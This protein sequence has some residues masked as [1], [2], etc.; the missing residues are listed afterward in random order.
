MISL[1]MIV[2]N[3]IKYIE[4]CLKAVSPFV[5]EIIVVDTGS[6]DGTLEVIKKFDCKVFEFTWCDDFAKA[7]NFSVSKA[8]ND[9]ILFLDADEHVTDFD[10][11][12]INTFIKKNMAN[13][14]GMISLKS[15]VGDLSNT[16]ID[17]LPRLFNKK[18]FKFVRPIHE[19][20]NP[21][22]KNITVATCDL[23]IFADHF[24]YLDS[25]TT[26]KDKNNKYIETLSNALSN[27]YDPYLEKH[28]A[29]ALF[30]IK[31]HEDCIAKCDN[32]LSHKNAMT[33]DYY[34]EVVTLKLEALIALEKFDDA[35]KMES[36]FDTCKDYDNYLFTMSI[37][38]INVNLNETAL[39]IY[40]YLLNKKDLSINRLKVVFAIGELMFNCSV[41]DEALRWYK[42]LPTAPDILEK[43]KTCESHLDSDESR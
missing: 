14:I 25:T 26:D 28:L 7:R 23:P 9:W 22:D 30:N 2:K 4:D 40:E 32:I 11:P 35:V 39:D 36:Y 18:K 29:A 5:D 37:A 33:F 6:T 1:C 38:Y 15:Y 27:K 24:G 17:K 3:E 12:A 13:C 43:I 19:Y 21:T 34:C 31:K 10:K 8:S 16:S 20:L 41:Y 42:M